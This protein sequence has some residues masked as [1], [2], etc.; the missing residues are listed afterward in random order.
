MKAETCIRK[1]V[2]TCIGCM[3]NPTGRSTPA[4]IIPLTCWGCYFGGIIKER[5]KYISNH[6]TC[7][8][9]KHN[10]LGVAYM[11]A[12]TYCLM[13]SSPCFMCYNWHYKNDI[14]SYEGGW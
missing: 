14:R 3:N 5:R 10:T 7:I 4:E 13:A 11:C 6:R 12:T 8:G 9:C 2:K 1:K